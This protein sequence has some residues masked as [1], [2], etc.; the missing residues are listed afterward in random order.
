MSMTRTV[1][2]L[3]PESLLRV[4]AKGFIS[5]AA[6]FHFWNYYILLN[7]MKLRTFYNWNLISIVLISKQEEIVQVKHIILKLFLVSNSKKL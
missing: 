3:Q 1:N 2:K 7:K 6:E 5:A 4:H